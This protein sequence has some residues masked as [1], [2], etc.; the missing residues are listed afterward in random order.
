LPPYRE[1]IPKKREQY[2]QIKDQHFLSEK[3]KED[4]PH[5]SQDEKSKGYVQQEWWMFPCL[6]TDEKHYQDSYAQTAPKPKI[7]E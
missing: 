3:R 7:H 1:E 2:H 4:P 5:L 6:D